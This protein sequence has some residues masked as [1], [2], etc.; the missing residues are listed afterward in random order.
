MVFLLTALGT[1]G[2][3][4]GAAERKALIVKV[5]SEAFLILR[6]EQGG[7]P[8]AMTPLVLASALVGLLRDQLGAPATFLAGALFCLLTLGTLA[9]YGG[10]RRLS[11]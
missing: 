7:L 11:R 6:A 5:F 2:L 9:V 3:I 4:E 10:R 1:S 8:I